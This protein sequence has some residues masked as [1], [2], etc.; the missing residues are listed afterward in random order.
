M[1]APVR[2]RR[3]WRVLGAAGVIGGAVTAWA[4]WFTHADLTHLRCEADSGAEL[5]VD[6]KLH[7]LTS[8]EAGFP[9]ATFRVR[10]GK[11]GAGKTR[12]GDGRTPL[13]RYT[14]G[15]PGAS[16]AF[17]TFVP[18]HYPTESQ[19]R[20]GMTGSAVGIHGPE[21][22]V[23]WLGAFVNTF[24]TTDGCVGL[25]T[26]GEMHQLA[27]WLRRHRDAELTIR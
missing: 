22:H 5:F 7:R 12:E 2:R 3:G 19:K 6:T 17:G 24:D 27:E 25:A 4:F 20:Q 23:R 11:Q 10:I 14:L 9:K 26:D 21:R 13:G 18:I 8:C 15:P 1:N 16:G